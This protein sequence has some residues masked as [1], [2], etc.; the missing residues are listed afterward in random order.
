MSNSNDRTKKKH[1]RQQKQSLKYGKIAK[2]THKLMSGRT[3]SVHSK[4]LKSRAYDM[5][6]S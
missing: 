1:R 6:D 4:K 5:E 2:P 3:G